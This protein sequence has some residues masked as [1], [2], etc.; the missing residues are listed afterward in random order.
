[1]TS[2]DNIKKFL[3]SE[4]QILEFFYVDRSND[5]AMWWATYYDNT[6]SSYYGVTLIISDSEFGFFDFPSSKVLQ[7]SVIEVVI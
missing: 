1:M 5:G 6:M 4:F 2:Y 3:E 7:K